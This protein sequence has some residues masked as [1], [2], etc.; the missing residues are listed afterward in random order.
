MSKPP[1][2]RIRCV[3]DRDYVLSSSQRCSACTYEQEHPWADPRSTAPTILPPKG[4]P[5]QKETLL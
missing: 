5:K 4:R 2:I 3:C 1:A